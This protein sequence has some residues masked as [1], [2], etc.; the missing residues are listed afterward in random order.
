M[1]VTRDIKAYQKQVLSELLASSEYE[2]LFNMLREKEKSFKIIQRDSFNAEYLAAK[3]ALA[4]H[5]WELYVPQYIAGAGENDGKLLFKAVMHCFQSPKMLPLAT[6]FSE[7][8]YFET[9]KDAPGPCVKAALKLFERLGLSE[10][11]TV[12]SGNET[13]VSHS[14]RILAETLDGFR[15][16]FENDIMKFSGFETEF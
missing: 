12:T 11:V 4:A 5:Y 10:K 15:A 9:E 2:E 7:Y 6:A 1:T 16:S 14:F 3:L 8:I 13:T